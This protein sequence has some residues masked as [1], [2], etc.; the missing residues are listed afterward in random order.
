[1]YMAVRATHV[2]FA[3]RADLRLWFMKIMM[4]TLLISAMGLLHTA[5]VTPPD[6]SAARRVAEIDTDY[7][8]LGLENDIQVELA[9]KWWL[10]LHASEILQ[11]WQI[12]PN[13][14]ILCSGEIFST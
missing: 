10:S 11:L 3:A 14:F 9:R 13:C 2:T 6:V 12:V 4:L 7:F 8:F 1:M 5:R